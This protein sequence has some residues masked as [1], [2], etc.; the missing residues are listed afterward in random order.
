MLQRIAEVHILITS[1]FVPADPPFSNKG[2]VRFNM[3]IRAVGTAD[4]NLLATQQ[5]K[6]M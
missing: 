1:Y 6:K 2:E 5:S 3:D 4:P